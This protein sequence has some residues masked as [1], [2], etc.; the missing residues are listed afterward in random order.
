MYDVIARLNALPAYNRQLKTYES[1][2]SLSA[3]IETRYNT[4]LR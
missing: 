1:L 4:S 2:R 3:V